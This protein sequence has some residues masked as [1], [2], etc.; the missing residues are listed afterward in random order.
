MVARHQSEMAEV[1]PPALVQVGLVATA[2]C[3]HSLRPFLH[4]SVRAANFFLTLRGNVSWYSRH[5]HLP[6]SESPKAETVL[7]AA[8]GPM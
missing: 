3:P 5:C 1:I 4:V 7:A 6:Q 2:P 8:S